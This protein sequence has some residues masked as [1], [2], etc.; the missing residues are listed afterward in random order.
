MEDLTALGYDRGFSQRILRLL[1][2]T[3]QLQW[4]LA[5]GKQHGCVPLT[6]VHPDY[7]PVLRKKL[8]GGSPGCL[9]AK[10]P[11]SL[12][13][14]P[15]ISLVGS[16]ELLPQNRR[17]AAEAGRQAAL[18]GYTLV[19][20]GARGADTAAQEACLGAGG[21]VICVVPDRLDTL[22]LHPRILYLSEEDLDMPF[23]SQRALSRN[24]VI[25]GLGQL[26][27]VAQCSLRSGG[28]WSGSC[29]NLQKHIS[30]VFC[31]QDGSPAQ[32]ELAAMGA[33]PVGFSALSALSRLQP[34]E[35]QLF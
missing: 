27:L 22:S 28:T 13:Q 23:S 5:Q 17:F 25:H 9:W 35:I 14:T 26:V 19:S 1:G 31:Y 3:Q 34:A 29:W 30:P 7:P 20:G 10:G 6:R 11:V 16:R 24:R 33:Q 2:R 21:R 12:L 4:Y 15:C 32:T 8:G 18:Q